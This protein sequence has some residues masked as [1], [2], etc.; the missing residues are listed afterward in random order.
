M[1]IS[2]CK[3]PIFLEEV[4]SDDMDDNCKIKQLLIMIPKTRVYV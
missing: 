3:N 1:E 4:D 2:H